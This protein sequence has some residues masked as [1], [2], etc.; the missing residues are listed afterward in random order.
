MEKLKISSKKLSTARNQKIPT[1]LDIIR[2]FF[3]KHPNRKIH[4]PDVVDWVTNEYKRRTGKIFRDP[5]RG[6]RTLSQQGFL[7]KHSQGI[8]EYNPEMVK[9]RQLEDFSKAQKEFILKRD[10]YRCAICGKGL[11]EGVTL[12]IDHIKPKEF[13]GKAVVENGQVIMFST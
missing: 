3:I 7:I 6:I 1:Q 12:H 13:G 2:E 10:G 4:T 11:K 9:N 8:Y 5:D